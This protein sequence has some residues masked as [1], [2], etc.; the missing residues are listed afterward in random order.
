MSASSNIWRRV[1]AAITRDY[2]K[3][4]HK[5]NKQLVVLTT[6]DLE[7]MHKI[8]LNMLIE[9]DKICRR[10]NIKYILDAGTLLG[11]VRHKGFIP[12]DDDI[13]VRMLRDDYEKFCVVANK[14]LPETMFFQNYKNDKGYPWMYSK[15]RMKGTK[16]VRIGQDRLN[17]EEGIYMDIFPCD[18]VPDDNKKKKKHNRLAKI[19]RKILY[20]RIGKYSCDKWYERLWWSLVCVIPRSYVYKQS[21]KLV[22]KYTEHNCK[23]VGT[24]GWHELPDVNGFLNGYFTDLTEVEFEGHMFYAPRDWDGFLTYSFGKDYMQ[25]PPVEQ[26][27]KDPGLVEFNL[28]DNF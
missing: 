14:E 16:A 17:M 19:Y 7:N 1:Y 18:G 28:G 26:R 22:K 4:I 6:S 23:R 12:W 5:V 13:D 11:A 20:A 2:K 9:F 27:F 8:Q 10:N 24:I 25:L 3:E 15:I 21:D